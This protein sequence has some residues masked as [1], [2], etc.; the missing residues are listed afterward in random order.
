MVIADLRGD[1]L[2]LCQITAHRSDEYSVTILNDDYKSGSLRKNSFVRANR[3]FT[4]D[5]RII[6]KKIARLKEEKMRERYRKNYRNYS[7]L[8]FTPLADKLN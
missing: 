6:V 5:Y 3:I 2:I 8:V 4:A 1:N 7:N